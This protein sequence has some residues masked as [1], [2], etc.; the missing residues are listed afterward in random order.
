[1]KKAIVFWWS[2]FWAMTIS[3][4]RTTFAGLFTAA[5]GFSTVALEFVP[6]QYV[7]ATAIFSV[8]SWATRLILACLA[9]DPKK[10]LATYD[11]GTTVQIVDSHEK[12]DD[13]KAKAVKLP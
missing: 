1:M 4:P 6:K 9:Y 2:Y 5:A 12:P 11:K 7:K 3:N 10:Q 8:L 13:P